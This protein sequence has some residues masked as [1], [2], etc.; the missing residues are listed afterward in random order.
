MKEFSPERSY[1][2]TGQ[3]WSIPPPLKPAAEATEAMPVPEDAT[4]V[5]DDDEAGGAVVDKAAPTQFAT[6]TLAG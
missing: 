5:G 1:S 4:D 6:L 3:A 2:W